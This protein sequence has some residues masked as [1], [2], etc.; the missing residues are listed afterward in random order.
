MERLKEVKS[1][2]IDVGLDFH[3]R[4][5]KTLA[6]QLAR[7][8]EPH[9]PLFIEEP[10]LP[11][12]VNELKKLYEQTTIPIAVSRRFCYQTSL[13]YSSEVDITRAARRTTLHPS[14]RQTLL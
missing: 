1:V 12:H 2:G 13:L 5:H 6:K 8:L 14:R 7:A 9:K 3:G 4:V 10:L 11:G